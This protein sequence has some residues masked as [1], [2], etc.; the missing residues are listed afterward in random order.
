M[1]GGTQMGKLKRKDA[2]GGDDKAV[3]ALRM[4]SS[5]PE[6]PREVQPPADGGFQTPC[7][8]TGVM[9]GL[10]GGSLGYVFGFG[11]WQGA[12]AA[13]ASGF[14]RHC[15]RHPPPPAATRR[16]PP[17]A[18]SAHSALCLP[19]RT[20]LTPARWLLDAHA[21]KWAVEGVP[22][23]G[24][25]V[26]QGGLAVPCR[27]EPLL[28]SAPAAATR[29]ALPLPRHGWLLAEA[30]ML[31]LLLL[32]LQTFA[33]MGGLYAAVNCFMLRLRRKQDGERR[34]GGPCRFSSLRSAPPLP[35][36]LPCP[37]HPAW[38]PCSARR[39]PIF[40][41]CYTALVSYVLPSSLWLALAMQPGMGRPRDVP[42]GW[43][44]AGSRGP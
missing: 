38:L 14:E 26:G 43:R 1:I 17:P 36:P 34:R 30:P 32:L 11:E 3:M 28:L 13:P 39:S 41:A 16:H 22:G 10:S 6:S 29:P 23:R 37:F 15:R 4:D 18:A 25:G 19:G 33:I 27:A 24:L 12:A 42:P 7:T 40:L 8:L 21:Q 2:Q 35:L 20:R 31:L 44:W 5:T 9:A